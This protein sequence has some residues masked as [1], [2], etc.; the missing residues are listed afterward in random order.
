MENK[1]G[2]ACLIETC[3][4]FWVDIIMHMA[5]YSSVRPSTRIKPHDDGKQQPL[6]TPWFTFFPNYHSKQVDDLSASF[7]SIALRVVAYMYC[8]SSLVTD[9]P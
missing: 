5:L 9:I 7:I 8:V 2:S 4:S 6:M 1:D 3:R